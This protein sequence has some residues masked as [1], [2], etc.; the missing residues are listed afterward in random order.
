MF[1]CTVILSAQTKR[2]VDRLFEPLKVKD[3]TY[4]GKLRSDFWGSEYI[5]TPRF[6]NIPT[7]KVLYCPRVFKLASTVGPCRDIT[8]LIDSHRHNFRSDGVDDSIFPGSASGFI[9]H[10]LSS[11]PP[12]QIDENTY[13]LNFDTTVRGPFANWSSNY[14]VISSVKNFKLQSTGI[15]GE[16]EGFEFFKTGKNRYRMRWDSA[17]IGPPEAASIGISSVD[18]KLCTQ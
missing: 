17:V 13:T 18:K 3:E 4:L 6:S 9:K 11:V 16:V 8:V 12:T 14:P 10:P 5:F 7:L 1:R 2:Y 15:G